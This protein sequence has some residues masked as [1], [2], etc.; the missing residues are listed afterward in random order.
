VKASRET[1]L[2]RFQRHAATQALL[3]PF[4]AALAATG[5]PALMARVRDGVFCELAEDAGAEPAFAELDA[6]ALSAD[7]FALGARPRARQGATLGDRSVLA[8]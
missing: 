5:R 7:L 4:G 3:E 8:V 6:G 1:A 2:S